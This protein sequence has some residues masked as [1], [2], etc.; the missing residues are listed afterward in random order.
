MELVS[1][2]KSN[3][4]NLQGIGKGNQL[5]FLLKGLKQG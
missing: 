4:V 1:T 5:S 2:R 3:L